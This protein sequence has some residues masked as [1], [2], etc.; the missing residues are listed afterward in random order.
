MTTEQPAYNYSSCGIC[1]A[2]VRYNKAERKW[3]HH[4]SGAEKRHADHAATDKEAK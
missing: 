4:G 1:G 3:K 2:M